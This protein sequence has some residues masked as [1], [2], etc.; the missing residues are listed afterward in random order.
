MESIAQTL[1]QLFKVTDIAVYSL[2]QRIINNH[3]ALEP[4]NALINFFNGTE[5]QA[6]I[7]HLE[8]TPT[9]RI[10]RRD[11]EGDVSLSGVQALLT[12]Q[13][14]LFLSGDGWCAEYS[15]ERDSNTLIIS[16][17]PHDSHYYTICLTI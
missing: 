4:L 10:V 17:K 11:R 3:R 5:F 13:D 7:T 16:V 9:L 2:N 12:A 14:G 8:M 15:G 6:V 1:A